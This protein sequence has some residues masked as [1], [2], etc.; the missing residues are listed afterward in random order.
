VSPG[1]ELPL[2]KTSPLFSQVVQQTK[3]AIAAGPKGVLT[4]QSVPS[5]ASVMLDGVPVG[6]TP[7]SIRDVPLGT[8]HWRVQL[9][10]G[11]TAGG[12]V[13]VEKQTQVSAQPQGQTPESKL[14]AAV[15]NNKLDDG[16]VS[17][18]KAFAQGDQA[19][20]VVFGALAK[21]GSG[22]ALYPFVLHVPSGQVRRLPRATFDAELLSAG[23]ELLK[24]ASLATK[25]DPGEAV[26]VPSA[27]AKDIV[28]SRE[29]TSEVRYA[30][31]P[32]REAAPEPA[33]PEAP[34]APL[35]GG[36]R[37]PLGRP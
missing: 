3:A 19:S 23:V 12:L 24:L 1:R 2:A 9:P 36:K 5:N 22:L 33:A 35:E 17:A 8:H 30:V 25:P 14:L 31:E 10:N 37:K 21:E 29:R 11:E 20:H 28:A 32:V 6:K 34:R 26:K 27:V 4:V 7:L 18:A 16:A 13:E 15:A